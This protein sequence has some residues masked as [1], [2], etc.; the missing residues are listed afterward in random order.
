MPKNWY[1]TEVLYR[2]ALQEILDSNIL[3]YQHQ[4]DALEYAISLIQKE[5]DGEVD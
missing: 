5:I 2:N 1:E 3:I 4:I